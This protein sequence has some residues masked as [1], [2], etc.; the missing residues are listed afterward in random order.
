M[1]TIYILILLV[2]A[3]TLCYITNL[4]GDF[5]LISTDAAGAN[6]WNDFRERALL[7]KLEGTREALNLTNVIENVFI[8]FCPNNAPGTD[9]IIAKILQ[10]REE[11]AA[12]NVVLNNGFG[13]ESQTYEMVGP[14]VLSYIYIYMKATEFLKKKN[15]HR[16]RHVSIL[17]VA[18]CIQ[19]KK[20]KYINFTYLFRKITNIYMTIY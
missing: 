10:W 18:V 4:L 7:G 6:A 13:L 19:F 16:R 14:S 8:A 12:V 11:W 20:L 17:L 15:L 3:L 1:S 9:A 5:K 2:C